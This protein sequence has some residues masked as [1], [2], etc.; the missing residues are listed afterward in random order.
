MR[1]IKSHATLREG[2]K[3]AMRALGPRARAPYA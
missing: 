1:H 3:A 2:L